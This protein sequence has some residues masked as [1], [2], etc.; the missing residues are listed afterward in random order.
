MAPIPLQTLFTLPIPPHESKDCPSPGGTITVSKIN[1]APSASPVPS[2]LKTSKSTPPTPIYLLTH[3]SPPD[4]RLTP[5]FLSTYLAALTHLQYSTNPPYPPGLLLTTSS[6]PKFYSNGLDLSTFMLDPDMKYRYLYPLFRKLLTYPM[7]TCAVLNG[8]TFA[9][10]FI[11]AMFHDYRVMNPHRGYL[12]MNELEFDAELSPAMASVFRAKLSNATFRAILLEAKRFNA[13]AALEAGI[14]DGLGG[15]EEAVKMMTDI[16]GG[17]GNG[18][19]IVAMRGK[20][21]VYGK[22]KE[23]MYRDVIAT[24]DA[25][26]ADEMGYLSRRA[27]KRKEQEMAE[28]IAAEQVRVKAKL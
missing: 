18:A 19:R 14:V 5:S 1:L 28:K 2:I 16:E 24:L 21:N 7:P 23:E 12:C 20:G 4:T 13:L 8:H 10:G 17:H 22:H 27:Q 9:G 25:S 15:L 11:L 6:L 26:K 3:H